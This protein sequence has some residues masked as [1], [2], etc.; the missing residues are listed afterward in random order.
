MVGVPRTRGHPYK[1]FLEQCRL[2]KRKYCFP[3]RVVHVVTLWNS[4][5]THVVMATTVNQ[6]KHEFDQY[7]TDS[8]Q[9]YNFESYIYE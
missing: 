2:L 1:V 9:K 5:S 3:N 8:K 6:F 7:F 4:I